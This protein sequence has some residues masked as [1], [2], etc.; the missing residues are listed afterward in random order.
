MWN[1]RTQSARLDARSKAAQ[2]A[3]EGNFAIGVGQ[4]T[5]AAE[6]YEAAGHTLERE[7]A[8]TRRANDKHVLMFLAATQYYLGGKFASARKLAARIE[9]RLLPASNR[10][11][12]SRFMK[13]VQIRSSDNY[14]PQMRRAYFTTFY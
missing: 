4:T 3:S 13:D 1:N 12:F 10:S 2:L 9:G 14:I 11:M 6:K 8:T 5:L 7:A